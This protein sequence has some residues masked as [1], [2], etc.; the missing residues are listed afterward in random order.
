MVVFLDLSSEKNFPTF[1]RGVEPINP[2]PLNTALAVK[3]Y[4]W[5]QTFRKT[6]RLQIWG[7][8]VS[9][10]CFITS[11]SYRPHYASCPSVSQSRML[12]YSWKTNRNRKTEFGANVHRDRSI[13]TGPRA[14][15]RV[16]RW[17]VKVNGRRIPQ[18]DGTITTCT[19]TRPNLL[20][21]AERSATAQRAAY[22]V[23]TQPQD[24]AF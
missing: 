20:P 6:V 4:S 21:A 16:R 22:H 5:T 1:Q 15:F 2:P 12:S 24:H 7:E 9:F 23:G 17:K 19:V 13:I 3:M 11:P 10:V 8:T 18:E 14:N